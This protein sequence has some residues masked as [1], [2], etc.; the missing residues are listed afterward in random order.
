MVKQKEIDYTGFYMALVTDGETQTMKNYTKK[1]KDGKKKVLTTYYLNKAALK[2]SGID[3]SQ[4]YEIKKVDD[5]KTYIDFNPF[6]L[7]KFK[8]VS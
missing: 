7:D 6:K 4:R 8:E 5:E 3:F 1:S 2:D